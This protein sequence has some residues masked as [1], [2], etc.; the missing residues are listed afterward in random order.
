M[1]LKSHLVAAFCL[2]ASFMIAPAL[3]AHCDALDGPVVLAAQR[4]L[5]GG[6][7]TPVLRWV[8]AEDEPAIREAFALATKVRS[9]GEAAE[10]LAGT[11]F[12]ETVVR[13]HRQGEGAPYTG[14]KPAGMIDP[15]IA[16]AD[17]AL[18]EK[19]IEAMVQHATEELASGLRRRYQRVN[20]TAAHADD[21][22]EAGREWVEAYVDYVHFIERMHEVLSGGAH[23]EAEPH[24]A[25]DAH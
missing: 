11:Y 1:K 22:V 8:R 19:S 20:E 12:F 13:I 5:E 6:D 15:P 25:P 17:K 23:G 16:H 14:L 21:G 9:E 3:L 24:S 2:I 18:R 4:A 7:V 10:K